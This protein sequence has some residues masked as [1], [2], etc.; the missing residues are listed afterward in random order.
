MNQ[1][2]AMKKGYFVPIIA[3]LLALTPSNLIAGW[4]W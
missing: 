3:E 2:G 4:N 1:G